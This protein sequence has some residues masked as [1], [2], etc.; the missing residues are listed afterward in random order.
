MLSRDGG[1]CF[2]GNLHMEFAVWASVGLLIGIVLLLPLALTPLSRVSALALHPF[3]PVESRLAS[4][5]LTPP[6]IADNAYSRR[7][8]FCYR[9]GNWLGKLLD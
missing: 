4:R 5:Q 2:A 3:M 1:I 8:I 9:H 6:S 7:D